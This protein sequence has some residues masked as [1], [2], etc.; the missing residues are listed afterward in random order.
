MKK[1]IKKIFGP[2]KQD[3]EACD[4]LKDILRN[5]ESLDDL[6]IEK[7][8]KLLHEFKG[9]HDDN[10]SKKFDLIGF[11]E[12]GLDIGK[13]KNA[14]R[15]VNEYGA[16]LFNASE[17]NR[18]IVNEFMKKIKEPDFD[19]TSL[20]NRLKYQFANKFDIQFLPYGKDQIRQAIEYMLRDEDDVDKVEKLRAGLVLLDDFINFDELEKNGST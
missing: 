15:I 19:K 16:A 18:K 17:H 11:F 7:A 13:A 2:K 1:I 6:Q 4:K 12:A 14:E 10:V 20:T 8:E 3:Q 5:F 9:H